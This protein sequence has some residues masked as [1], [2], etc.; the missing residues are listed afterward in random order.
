MFQNC[1]D[2]AQVTQDF[3]L[4]LWWSIYQLCLGEIVDLS[5][6]LWMWYT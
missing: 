6:V 3:Y 2:T 1:K 5:V 4:W